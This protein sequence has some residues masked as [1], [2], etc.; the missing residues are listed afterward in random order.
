V[1]P[2]VI[3]ALVGEGRRVLLVGPS[4]AAVDEALPDAAGAVRV[5][6]EP[7]A[8]SAEASREVDEELAEIA[9][10][11]EEIAAVD[12]EVE[13]LRTELGDYDK[14]AYRAASARVDA[15]RDLDELRPRLREAEAS[16][17]EARR[18]VVAAATELR[19]ALDAQAALAPVRAALRQARLANEGLGVLEQRQR[20]LREG[21]AALD[22]EE[23]PDGWRA[24][25]QHRRQAVAAD[26]ELN[27]FTS[28]AAM[29]RRR[30]LDAQLGARAAIGEHTEADIAAAD[31]RLAAA[32]HA[33][34]GADEEY[35]SARQLLTGLRVA[36]EEAESWGAPTAEDRELVARRLLFRQARLRELAARQDGASARRAALDTR[37]HELDERAAALR[38]EADAR[39]VG[40]AGVVA[41]TL[42]RSRVHPALVGAEFDVVIVVGAG[43]AVP[44]EV[45][46]VLC[47]ATTTA[48]LIGGAPQAGAATCFSHL[49]ITSAAEAE[50]RDGCTVLEDLTGVGI[51][52]QRDG[53]TRS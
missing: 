29:G 4:D 18:A 19:A 25:R 41:T 24:R 7:P 43:A 48:V 11:L 46:L 22:A 5:G 38:A 15:E 32:E 49:G 34:T 1:L 3:E 17:D 39:I 31:E 51:P 35:Q 44:A 26:A 12:A 16:A 42:A 28:V 20:A 23:R 30:W 8:G 36:V 6:A 45:L 33:V 47:R 13:R 50:A 40:E 37:R 9:A 10:E 21:R 52:E 53:S 27:R 14:L 2:G